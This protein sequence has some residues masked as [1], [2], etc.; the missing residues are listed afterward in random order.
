P[1]RVLLL[2]EE[3]LGGGATRAVDYTLLVFR[4][5]IPGAGVGTGETGAPGE[6][7]A[8]VPAELSKCYVDAAYQ[9]TGM[10]DTLLAATLDVART[11]G[12][13]RVWLGTNRVNGRARRFYARH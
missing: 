1:Q 9:G 3:D 4:S 2:A 13:E 7:D 6:D 5:A 11:A 8:A 10:A 12:A